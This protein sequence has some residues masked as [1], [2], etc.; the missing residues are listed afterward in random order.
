M[1]LV[2]NHIIAV[3][4]NRQRKEFDEAKHQ[5]MIASIGDH[6]LLSPLVVRNHIGGG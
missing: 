5:E 2:P 3:A 4:E 6:G 1:K